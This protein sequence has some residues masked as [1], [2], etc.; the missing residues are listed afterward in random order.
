[1]AGWELKRGEVGCSEVLWNE[2]VCVA[3]LSEVRR[4]KARLVFA[5]R[6]LARRGEA[7]RGKATEQRG[8][9]DSIRKCK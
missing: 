8:E 3:S 1:M 7:K 4:G 5:R 9:H 2:I 6:C